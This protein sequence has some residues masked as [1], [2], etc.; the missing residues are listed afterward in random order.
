MFTSLE[1][2]GRRVGAT[3]APRLAAVK[4]D[5][6]ALPRDAGPTHLGVAAPHLDSYGATA[7]A[8]VMS[9]RDGA[10]D[11][12]VVDDLFVACA[13]LTAW[14][15]VVLPKASRTL[16]IPADAQ[17]HPTA[18]V[19]NGAA[20]G[21][22]VTLGANVVVGNGAVVGD[23]ATVGPNSVISGRAVIRQRVQIGPGCVIGDAGFSFIRDGYRWLKLPSFG[24]ADIGEDAHILG[25]T[26]VHA[27]VFGSTR[28]GRRCALDSHVLIG[29]DSTIG[30]D[31]AIA[32]HSAA[33]GSVC[34]GAGCR[35]GGKVGVADGVTIA[36]GVTVTGGSLVTRSLN[37]PN[38]RYSSGWPAEHSG[39]WWRRIAKLKRKFPDNTN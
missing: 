34:I 11:D 22:G 28:I 8:A 20:I 10:L 2:L 23:Y 25:H 14:L 30:D 9:T 21:R 16:S 38:S 33:A 7:A 6:L 4:V 31:T 12:F 15:T 13:R 27:G 29:H 36:D 19:E 35:I 18:T 17:I 1:E 3:V 26:V 37:R 32:G 39:R 24:T 5:G